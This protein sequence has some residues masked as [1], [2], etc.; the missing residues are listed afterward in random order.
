M[1]KIIMSIIFILLISYTFYAQNDK[2]T[3]NIKNEEIN[4]GRIYFPKAFVHAKK[5]YNRGIYRVKFTKKDEIP[6]F[7]ILN[8]K[9]ELLFEELAIIKPY[10]GKYKKFRYRLKREML[11][12][13]EYFRIKLTRP[14][15]F[16]MAYFL[17]KNKDKIKEEKKIDE[18][19][20]EKKEIKQVEN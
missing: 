2:N 17:I 4:L 20:V 18:T 6:Y 15:N 8:K 7:I 12:G 16:Y 10:K 19:K 14:D 9:K 5:D 11:R 1:K 13:Y 3:Q